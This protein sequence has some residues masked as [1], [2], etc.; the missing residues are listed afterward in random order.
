[1]ATNPDI[2]LHR[3]DPGA[4]ESDVQPIL[5][6]AKEIFDAKN[7]K[8]DHHV[9]IEGWIKNLNKP[10]SYILYATKPGSDEIIGLL[11]SHMKHHPE[12]ETPTLHLWI[13]GVVESE[14]KKGVFRT[15]MIEAENHA[16]ELGIETLGMATYPKSFPRMAHVLP[17]LDGFKLKGW[18]ADMTKM[19]FTKPL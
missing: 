7:R 10:K 5:D 4:P 8:V 16:R 6:R 9:T 12:Y 2:T 14:R 13:T 19:R 18:E 3:I 1:M 11:F 17:R 15:L